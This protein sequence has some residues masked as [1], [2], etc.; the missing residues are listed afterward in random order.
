MTDLLLGVRINAS[1][2]PQTVKEIRKIDQAV[3]ELQKQ[4]ERVANTAQ[5]LRD[6]YNLSD[7]EVDQLV[8]ELK[9]LEQQTKRATAAGDDLSALGIAIKT[10]LVDVL[11]EAFSRATELIGQFI[12]STLEVGGAAEQANVAFT[13][14]LGSAEEAERVLGNL[15]DFAATT[16]FDLPGVRQAGQ[17]LLAFGFTADELIPTLTAVGDVAAGTNQPFDELAEIYG[18]A[19]TQ[20]RLFAEDL[21]QFTGRGIPLVAALAE[22]FGVAESEVRELVRSGQVGFEQLEQAFFDLTAEGAQF[23][24]LMEAQ[25]RTIPG[26][27]SNIEDSFVRFQESVFNAFSP[28]VA[29]G[30]Q[31][32]SD[33]FEEIA[34]NSAGLDAITDA[35]ERLRLELE[36]S[37]EIAERLGEAFAV[38][39]DEAVNQI[40]GLIDGITEFVSKENN[41]E[42]IANSI[43][44]LA[45]TVQLLGGA[46]RFVIALTDGIINLGKEFRPVINV[47]APSVA[48]ITGLRDAFGSLG[49]AINSVRAQLGLIDPAP[50]QALGGSVDDLQAASDQLTG[51][52][53]QTQESLNNANA[54]ELDGTVKDIS[55]KYDELADNAKTATDNLKTSALEQGASAEEIAKIESDALDQRIAQSQ[56]KLSEL[57]AVNADSLSAD[58][59]EKLAKEI[60]D[61]E[62]DIAGDRLEVAESVRDAQIEAAKQARDAAVEAAKEQGDALKEARDEAE[63]LAEQ[64]FGDAATGRERD[65]EGGARQRAE[66]FEDN[67]QAQREAGQQR[68]EA[69]RQNSQDVLER[70]AEAFQQRQQREQEA[71]EKG[72]QDELSQGTAVID[73]A[74]AEAEFQTALRLAQDDAERQ[75]L[76]DERERAKER[77]EILAEEQV[78]ALRTVDEAP[79]LTP[80]EQA[81]L[82][83]EE[84][85]EA[86]RSAFEE[87]QRAE[88]VAFEEQQQ[89][90]ERANEQAIADL[91]RQ[92]QEDLQAQQR[93]FEEQE[94]LTEQAFKD[95][96]LAKERAFKEEQRQLDIQTAERVRGILAQAEAANPIPRFTGGPLTAGGLYSIAERGP[97]VARIGAR[98]YLFQN[99]ALI[100]PQT[101]GYVYNAAQTAQRM[102]FGSGDSVASLR[103]DI[104]HL[105][106]VIKSRPATQSRDT[107]VLNT[108]TPTQD[109]AKISAGKLRNMARYRGLG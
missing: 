12:T 48:V 26:Q 66:S 16:P 9:K 105:T 55:D 71:F 104:Q 21:N 6:A 34:N 52:L 79:D 60:A 17:Q 43:E 83:L 4:N 75:Q 22:Q 29:G 18:K 2:G 98:E 19:R 65:F 94:R 47:L 95:A 89:A 39:F 78:K 45:D 91:E 76:Q 73:A 68:I 107:Y 30:L 15:S 33:I 3:K 90:Q 96:E 53:S 106:S 74:A 93:A 77:A 81:R 67:L 38:L 49:D 108:R 61:T 62:A 63:R 32:L 92:L 100:Q 1:G 11:V 20:G 87:Q 41:I 59:Q 86:K 103:R 10:K 84:Q 37:P 58:E 97:E 80:V 14:I 42:A 57:Q 85:I 82:D 28:A 44:D 99:P 27:I 109:A 69:I 101:S 54:E 64:S 25:S 56:Q 46:A 88:A 51:A 23:G 31:T 8:D 35:S 72:L 5:A 40:A 7:A 24:G 50:I 102:S 70:Q 13:T 36:A